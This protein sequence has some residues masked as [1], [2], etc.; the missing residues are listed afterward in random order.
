[1]PTG[2]AQV[3]SISRERKVDGGTKQ[4]NH[5]EH[6]C[7]TCQRRC[8]EIKGPE[9]P[10]RWQREGRVGEVLVTSG[11]ALATVALGAGWLAAGRP[12]P[13]R[14]GRAAGILSVQAVGLVKSSPVWS[15]CSPSYPRK[16]SPGASVS[17]FFWQADCPRRSDL[18]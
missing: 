4:A 6:R 9:R 5:C 16:L 18:S 13:G 17:P 2:G 10:A 7:A 12:A 3:A 14:H 11:E 8:Q 1:M 15:P